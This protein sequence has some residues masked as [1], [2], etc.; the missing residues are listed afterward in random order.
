MDNNVESL[1]ES[2][3][4]VL[5]IIMNDNDYLIKA[6]DRLTADD[7]YRTTH[8][9]IYETMVNLYKHNV[10]FDLLIL[11]NNLKEEIDKKAV[12][13]SEITNINDSFITKVTFDSHLEII[14]EES[15]K[16]TIQD[17]CTRLINS[18]GSVEDKVKDIQNVLLNINSQKE[19]DEVYTATEVVFKT[20]EKIERASNSKNGITGIPTGVSIL[21]NAIN[22]LERGSMVV[23]GARPSMGKTAF[24]LKMIENIKANVLYVQLDMTLD[25]MGQRMLATDTRISNSRIGKGRLNDEQYTKLLESAGRIERKRNLFFYSPGRATIT[26]ILFKAKEIKIKYGLDVI[27]ID[28]IGKIT[29]ETRGTTYE[30]MT[31][32]SNG[33]KGMARELDVCAVALCQLSRGVEQR[34]DKHPMLSDLRDSGA[35][36]EDADVIGFLYRD[37]YYEDKNAK[38]DILEVDFQ[39]SRNGQTGKIA[40]EYNLV[41]QE[42]IQ[43]MEG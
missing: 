32:I 43:I 7:F 6:M 10:K 26:K 19:K 21:D 9:I 11:I 33:I 4:C 42:L 2:E 8:K 1:V 40:F 36:E 38:T 23:I 18:N 39:K 3:R 16:R 41:T 35:I 5:G 27:I 17:M 13:I 31:A 29:P 20:L 25:G 34:Q 30:N 28:H 14:I 15:R 37:G 22:G 24:S 12:T